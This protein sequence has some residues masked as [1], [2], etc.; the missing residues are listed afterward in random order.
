M[1]RSHV[2]TNLE[3]EPIPEAFAG[4]V[5]FEL[6]VPCPDEELQA[7]IAR[8]LE[9]GLPDIQADAPF[10]RIIAGGPS[11][12]N[13]PLDGVTLALNG[14]LK[15]FTDRGLAPT[16]WACCDPQGLIVEKFLDGP[17]PEETIYLVA[18]KCPANV[19]DRLKGRDVRVWHVSDHAGPALFPVP[20]GSTVT[21][22]ALMLA[23]RLGFPR[24][25]VWGWDCSFGDDG[26]THANPQEHFYHEVIDLEVDGRRFKST[27]SWLLEAEDLGNK[28]WPVLT[29]L[30]LDIRVM[31][32]GMLA[33][34][35][36]GSK[37]TF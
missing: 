9:R 19:F 6:H 20:C 1:G 33:T 34:Y 36:R 22:S 24:Q 21:T 31:G 8:T 2:A 37:A 30:G 4:V 17:L 3:L 16:Y 10:I 32:D 23:L 13:A 28:V 11:A 18:S 7:N 15:L 12:R 35:I 14:A 29:W 5:E 26:S 27:R 25:E